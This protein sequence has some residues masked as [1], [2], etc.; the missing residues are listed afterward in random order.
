[1]DIFAF[2]DLKVWHK[3]IDFADKVIRLSDDLD[4]NRKHFRL[5]E[6]LEACSASIAMNIAEGKGRNS[7]KEYV[8]FLYIARASTYECV[9]LLSLFYK[10]NWISEDKLKDLENDAKEIIKMI[11]GLINAISEK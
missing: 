8:Q 7:K 3:A 1:M 4:S 11:K 2:K 10:R 5:I 9:T 6:Q